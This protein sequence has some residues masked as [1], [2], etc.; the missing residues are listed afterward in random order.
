MTHH[1]SSARNEEGVNKIVLLIGYT[2]IFFNF[3]LF[4][5]SV[6]IIGHGKLMMYICVFIHVHKFSILQSKGFYT[7]LSTGIQ[8]ERGLSGKGQYTFK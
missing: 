7:D 4:M 5:T 8:E 1:K 2:L 6:G 3:R